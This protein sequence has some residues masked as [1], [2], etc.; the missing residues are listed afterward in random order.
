[1]CMH[2]VRGYM[3]ATVCLRLGNS[4]FEMV[5]SPC[6]FWELNSGCQAMSPALY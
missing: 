5:L 1:M 6:G 4:L 2:G 3:C